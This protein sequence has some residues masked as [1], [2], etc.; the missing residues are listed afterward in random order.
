MC[1]CGL[2]FNCFVSRSLSICFQQYGESLRASNRHQ[3]HW[4]NELR[5]K[6]QPFSTKRWPIVH[7]CERGAFFS[8]QYSKTEPKQGI[9]CADSLF[10]FRDLSKIY[11]LCETERQYTTIECISRIWQTGTCFLSLTTTRAK[12][13]KKQM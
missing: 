8:T 5:L 1:V 3:Q 6:L 9:L 7:L 2:I 4:K 12:Q 11:C 10:F 13:K